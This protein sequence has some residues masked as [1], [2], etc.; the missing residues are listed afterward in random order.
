MTYYW[1]QE[2]KG[3]GLSSAKNAGQQRA[4]GHVAPAASPGK[5]VWKS[6]TTVCDDNS[7]HSGVDSST[8][9]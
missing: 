2:K 7:N 6:R 3:A 5:I 1:S 8:L 9:M 4:F